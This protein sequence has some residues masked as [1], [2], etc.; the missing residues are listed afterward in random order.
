MRL[1]EVLQRGFNWFK[2]KIP[3]RLPAESSTEVVAGQVVDVEREGRS[4]RFSPLIVL[5]SA[6]QS[7]VNL[8]SS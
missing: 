3:E 1:K 7:E 4:L 6:T 5:Q 8:V 2:V